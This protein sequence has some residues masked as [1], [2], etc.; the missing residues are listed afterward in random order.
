MRTL[1]V[2]K[3]DE[4]VGMEVLTQD[5]HQTWALLARRPWHGDLPSRPGATTFVIIG[6]GVM[7]WDGAG[8]VIKWAMLPSV[9]EV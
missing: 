5:R 3:V 4:K 6:M 9:I 2:T 7:G 8:T 1:P